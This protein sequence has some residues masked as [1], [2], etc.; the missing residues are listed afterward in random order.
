MI[1]AKNVKSL[2][3]RIVRVWK[4]FIQDVSILKVCEMFHVEHNE[5]MKQNV[6]SGRYLTYGHNDRKLI[7]AGINLM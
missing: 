3:T 1:F 2:K 6:P 7:R 5:A 4:N